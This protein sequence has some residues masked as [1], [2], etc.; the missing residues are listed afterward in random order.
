MNTRPITRAFGATALVLALAAC[1]DGT[2]D[3]TTGGTSA[4]E[5]PPAASASGQAALFTVTDSWI[6]AADSGMTA[7]FGTLVNDGATDVVVTSAASDAS[8]V[9]ELH[10]TVQGSDGSTVMQPKAGGFV[11][12]A[13]G[14]YDLEPGGDHLMVMDLVR[15]L[16]PGETVRL[17]LTFADGSTADLDATVKSFSGAAEDYQSG[18]M[19]VDESSAGAQ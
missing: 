15:P 16:E 17:T 14:T 5:A 13:G 10:E 3:A 11:V 4:N 8:P 12:P 19:D 1:G 2:E 9:L 18:E 6:K 7:A